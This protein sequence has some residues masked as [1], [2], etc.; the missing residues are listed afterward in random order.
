M[1]DFTAIATVRPRAARFET[2]ADKQKIAG[3]PPAADTNG[4]VSGNYR[5]KLTGFQRAAVDL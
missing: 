2:D 1:L 4:R 3:S 5:L